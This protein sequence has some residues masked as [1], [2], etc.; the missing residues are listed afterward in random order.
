M[1]HNI[2]HETSNV[3]SFMSYFS[4]ISSSIPSISSIPSASTTINVVDKENFYTTTNDDSL[5]LCET[6]KEC[7]KSFKCPEKFRRRAK[8]YHN[9]EWICLGCC[10][11]YKS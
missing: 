11:T 5:S 9:H 2:K 4:S 8:N 6:C 7:K 3:L 1:Y 10:R